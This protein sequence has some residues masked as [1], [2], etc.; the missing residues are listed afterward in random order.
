MTSPALAL[1][2][3]LVT[4]RSVTPEDAGC[5]D[6][7][8]RRL[9]AVGFECHRIDSGP[10]SLRVANLWA[11]RR[12]GV[13]RT[14]A[15]A[16]HT[17]VVP[18]GPI[19]RWHSDQFVPTHR[20]GRLY[21]RGAADMK[22]SLAC[23]VVAAEEFVA[24]HP[25]HAGSIAFLIT[26]DEE[27]PALDGTTQVVRWQQ[28]R[29]ERIDACIVG[30]PTSVH[31]VGDMI[32]TGRRGSLS[33]RLTIIGKQGHVAYP[34]LAKNPIHTLAPAWAELATTHWVDGNAH[35]PPTSWQVSNLHAGG[36]ATNV[37]PGEAVVDFNF[38]FATASTPESLQQ[39][40]EAVLQCHGV[41][42]R[43]DWT[44]G[45]RPFLTE[46]GDLTA[47]LSASIEAA[48]GRRTQLS[49]T[50]GTSDGRFIASICPQVA[51]CGPVNASIHQIDEHVAVADIEPLKDIYRGTL[52]R[53]LL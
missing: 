26:S 50:G 13:G 3:Q 25:G 2:E 28:D 12:G 48:T 21:G 10:G 16:G 19:E 27:G 37:I 8:A 7:I 29:G 49:T 40:L 46:P 5:Q 39:R 20:D 9:A 6:L 53:Y 51:E 42:Y 44:L 4:R 38:R 33:G 34:Q 15:F 35:F 17:D 18:A 52:E 43:I 24:A 41:E 45:G 1:A 32:K 14:L 11:I 31:A 36:G 22:T 30:E 23:M 47:A